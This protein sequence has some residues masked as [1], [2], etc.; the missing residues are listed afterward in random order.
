MWAVATLTSYHFDRSV[1][2]N[3]RNLGL[4]LERGTREAR[5]IAGFYDNSNHHLSIYAGGALTPIQIG[6]A[7]LGLL[8]G[9][10]NGYKP[11]ERRFGP[12]VAPTLTF[13]VKDLGF[14]IVGAPRL[15]GH[16]GVLAL[17]VKGKF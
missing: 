17:Q 14:N 10:V 8:A 15:L 13:D 12:L 16:K 6:Q 11:H 7:G 3:E 9:M 4:G 2:H 1:E 5:L